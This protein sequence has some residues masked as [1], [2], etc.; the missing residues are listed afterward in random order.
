[1]K[2]EPPSLQPSSVASKKLQRANSH[3]TNA[4]AS[5]VE[6]LKRQFENVHRSKTAPRV[7]ASVRSTSVN[8]QSVNRAAPS[9]SPYQSSSS[10]SR[11]SSTLGSVGS[12]IDGAAAT[13][14]SG[15]PRG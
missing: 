11:P 10:K 2:T 1:M 4:V 8:V 12:D 15:R 9:S 13:A 3:A 6:E 14:S 7:E 5:W